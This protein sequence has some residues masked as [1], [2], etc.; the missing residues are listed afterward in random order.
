MPALCFFA[1]AGDA[2][3]LVEHL[4]E[5]PEIAF[6]VPPDGEPALDGL[7]L[8]GRH[9]VV[10]E[11]VYLTPP[12]AVKTAFD[13]VQPRQDMSPSLPPTG[14][15]TAEPQP[16]RAVRTVASLGDGHHSLWHMPAGKDAPGHSGTIGLDL[17]T[18]Y[19]PYSAEERASGG[20][21]LSP[22]TWPRE[23]LVSSAFQWDG[24]HYAPALKVTKQWW[25]RL[26]RW[27]SRT[28]VMLIPPDAGRRPTFYAFPSA[29]ARLKAGIKYQ[30]NGW[31]IDASI[32]A[33][34][35]P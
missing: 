14:N 6:L 29:L 28:C 4:N 13:A 16:W 9:F 20:V 2:R 11:A 26:Q 34:P 3:L 12:L 1:D 25:S 17:W 8:E 22:W 27:L 23:M 33:A 5:D 32:R 18:R 31:D 35:P 19:R 15:R 30:A 10:G 7:A 21:L 24:S